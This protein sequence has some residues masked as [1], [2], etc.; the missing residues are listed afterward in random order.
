MSIERISAIL[1]IIGVIGA[2]IAGFIG[3]LVASLVMLCLSIAILIGYLVYKVII[4]QREIRLL[5]ESDEPKTGEPII[6]S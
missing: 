4:L 2:I 3:N 5:R 1:G 6:H